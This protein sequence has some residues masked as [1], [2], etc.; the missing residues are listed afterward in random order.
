[1]SLGTDGVAGISAE[2]DTA[3]FKQRQ[4]RSNLTAVGGERRV[5]ALI[6]GTGIAPVPDDGKITEKPGVTHSM[7]IAKEDLGL[8]TVC[9]VYPGE[10][11][12]PQRDG[13]E[14]LGYA[15]I[16]KFVFP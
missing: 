1:M 13:M 3:K 15:R 10:L 5:A 4:P 6:I 8:D 11:S 9:L 2:A 7:T 16:P 12:F 14:T